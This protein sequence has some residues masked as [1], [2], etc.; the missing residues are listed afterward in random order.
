VGSVTAVLIAERFGGED[1]LRGVNVEQLVEIEG[2]GEV[3]ARA[4]VDYIALEDNR[5]LV[6]RL[7]KAGLNFE[8]ASSGPSEGPLAGK[9]VVITGT[10]SR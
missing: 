10:L 9:R 7:M 2:I 1:L 5:D 4:V 8:R 6:E 3:V